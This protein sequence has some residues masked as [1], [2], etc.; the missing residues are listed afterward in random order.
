MWSIPVASTTHPKSCGLRRGRKDRA[1]SMRDFE[2]KDK[3]SRGKFGSILEAVWPD[4]DNRVV[5]LKHFSEGNIMEYDEKEE[6]SKVKKTIF[7]EINI[8]SQ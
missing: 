6:T 7:N 8:H 3:V 1:W 4:C 2:V 5:A